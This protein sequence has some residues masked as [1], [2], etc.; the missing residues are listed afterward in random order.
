MHELSLAQ[1]ILSIVQQAIPPQQHERV[2]TIYLQIG[3]LSGIEIDAL[4]FSFDIIK[5][6]SPFALASLDIEIIEAQ[7][8]CN[9]CGTLFTY[10][11]Y[12]TPCPRCGSFSIEIIRGKEMR[13][14]GI[15]VD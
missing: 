11:T 14:S 3:T 2:R 4:T 12:G 10:E 5:E 7:G 13:V 15:D 6:S 8:K 1:S 9:G